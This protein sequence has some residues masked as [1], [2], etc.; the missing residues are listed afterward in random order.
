MIKIF[1]FVVLGS[2]TLSSAFG[3][4]MYKVVGPDGKITFSDRPAL[5]KSKKTSVMRSFVLRPVEETQ[6]AAAA[7]EAAK[8]KDAVPVDPNATVTPEV[9]ETMVTV[10]GLVQFGP[11]FDPMCSKTVEGAKAFSKATSLW[12]RRNA[13]YV[14]QQ[15]RLLMEVM[16]PK[17]RADLQDRATVFL[18]Q[19]LGKGAPKVPAGRQEWCDHAI[20][21]LDSGRSDI[22]HP[23][24]LAIPITK[25]R[26]E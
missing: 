24:M 21:E 9:E 6:A 25:Y 11:R 23:A 2:V 17:K 26:A 10:M 18:E 4:Q 1:L 14:E 12:K 8:K 3:Q 20:A 16:S 13:V 5:E 7:A 22:N 15:K 19:E